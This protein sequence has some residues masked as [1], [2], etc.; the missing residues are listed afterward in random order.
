MCPCK[1]N[2]TTGPARSATIK[3]PAK[4]PAAPR[5]KS[6]M[7]PPAPRPAAI[8]QPPAE[9]QHTPKFGQHIFNPSEPSLSGH[10]VSSQQ[11]PPSSPANP[12]TLDSVVH[13][14]SFAPPL[15]MPPTAS[16]SRSAYP[17]DIPSSD[18]ATLPSSDPPAELSTPPSSEA[19]TARP[20]QREAAIA[21]TSDTPASLLSTLREVP[22]L[23]NLPRAELEDLVAHVL[24]E[25]GFVKLVCPL[26]PPGFRAP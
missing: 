17:S 11:H 10:L 6:T 23:Y 20:V 14:T 24:R 22:A 16:A 4:P 13:P 12:G 26:R 8:A 7:K 5:T 1:A 18:L 2:P 15:S 25:D 9:R 3:P 19:P 21:P